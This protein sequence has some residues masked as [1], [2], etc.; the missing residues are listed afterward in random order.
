MIASLIL[1]QILNEFLPTTSED[2]RQEI[3]DFRTTLNC[4]MAYLAIYEI[5]TFLQAK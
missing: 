5:N 4:I 2:W 1:D 3:I